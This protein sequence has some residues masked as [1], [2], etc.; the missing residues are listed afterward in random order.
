MSLTA[1][2]QNAA[3]GLR[4]AQQGVD[5]VSRNISNAS[6]PGYTRK[7]LPQEAAIVDH[8]GHGV[9]TLEIRRYVDSALQRE[10]RSELSTTGALESTD[11]MLSRLEL[12]FGSPEDANSLANSLGRLNEAFKALATSPENVSIQRTA[13]ARAQDLTNNMNALSDTIQSLRTDAETQINGM[14][15]K[16]NDALDRIQS[17]N[18]D[19][20]RTKSAGF[21]IAD[22]EDRRDNAVNDLAQMIDIKYFVRDTGEMLVYTGTGRALLSG[23]VNQ[24]SYV[25]AGPM[26]PVASYPTTISGIMLGGADITTEIQGGQLKG[27]LDVRDTLLPKAQA[28]LDQLA[29]DL[30]QAFTAQN[31]ELFNDGGATYNPA[32]MLGFSA[33]ITVNAV[34]DA[35][36]WRM[37]DG[38]VVAAPNPFESDDTLPKAI[39]NMFDTQQAFPLGL[40]LGSSQTFEAYAASFISFQSNQRADYQYRLEGQTA[41]KDAL[42]KRQSDTSGV[43]VDQEMT[44]LVQLQASYSASARVIESV[45][46]M[47]DELLQS[48]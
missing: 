33:R 46:R 45:T 41:F 47:L 16:I 39:V 5:I 8:E 26:T 42:D 43:N 17:L 9:R 13:I 30:T 36:P 15:P 1:A 22:L 18:N 23:G 3:S 35:N 44:M 31:L 27:F 25:T 24:L 29:S 40:G 6:T 19:I 11:R 7:I 2:L 14:V 34:V 28:Q 10:L 48:V 21:S 4:A 38:T 37:R 12:S 32:N 20:I